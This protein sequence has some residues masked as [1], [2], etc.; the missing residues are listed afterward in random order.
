[1]MRV[2]IYVYICIYE[3]NC[4]NIFRKKQMKTQR[5]SQSTEDQKKSH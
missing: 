5:K 1:M 3:D 4:R 2:Y